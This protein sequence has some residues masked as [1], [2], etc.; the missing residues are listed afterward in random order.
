MSDDDNCRLR[1]NAL[2]LRWARGTTVSCVAYNDGDTARSQTDYGRQVEELSGG[3]DR[4]HN[5]GEECRAIVGDR[6]VARVLSYLCLKIK[7][8]RYAAQA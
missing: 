8:S 5:A 3:G 1:L 7:S 4:L 2:Q 6:P